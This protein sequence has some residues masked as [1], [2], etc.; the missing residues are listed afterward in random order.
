MEE[1]KRSGM[2]ELERINKKYL[3]IKNEL[4]TKKQSVEKMKNDLQEKE[5]D[6]KI[7]DG[8]IIVKQRSGN[9]AELESAKAK[10]QEVQKEIKAI[11]ENLEDIKEE[12]QELDEKIKG[13]LEKLK[14]NPELKQHIE[15][16]LAKRYEREN[17]K[18]SK[19]K[20]KS[21]KD[22]EKEVKKLE[23]IEK[24]K[25]EIKNHPHLKNNLQGMLQ[26]KVDMNKLNDELATLDENDSADATR[27]SEIK[28]AIQSKAKKLDKNKN[29][30]LDYFKK[31]KID[32]N[33]KDLKDLE[34]S[35]ISKKGIADIDKT[36]FA[37][38]KE[39][40]EKIAKYDKEIKRIDKKMKI[41][42]KSISNLGRGAKVITQNNNQTVV[43]PSVSAPVSRENIEPE[44]DEKPKLK[45]WQF[46]QRWKQF[47][48]NRNRKALPDAEEEK[49]EET[50]K[51]EDTAKE[52]NEFYNS[53][54]YDVVKEMMSEMSKETYKNSKAQ[55]KENDQKASEEKED[56]K[57]E[58]AR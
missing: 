52:K 54:K 47:K 2:E 51:N 50:E 31:K 58:E 37:K 39:S 12:V 55:V 30:M 38:A 20:E 3:R 21:E 44:E 7:L 25:D 29:L 56:K 23:K 11:K 28:K 40:N 16:S 53:L 36:L 18:L 22:K 24:I 6:I 10:K 48:E 1:N 8:V 49:P 27:I 32:I 19:E 42:E 43:N 4:A 35:I 15:S 33:E 41:N 26:A 46:T 17:K 13:I 9:N 57:E 5:E 14:E 45:W 34:G